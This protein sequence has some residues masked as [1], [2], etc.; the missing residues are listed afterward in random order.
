MKEK[1]HTLDAYLGLMVQ[2]RDYREARDYRAWH[3]GW[4][5]RYEAGMASRRAAR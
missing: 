4:V 2:A 1:R 5:D 3:R